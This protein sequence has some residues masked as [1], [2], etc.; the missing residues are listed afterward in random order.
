MGRAGPYPGAIANRRKPHGDEED[1]EEGGEEDRQEV[2][3]EVGQEEGRLA[4]VGSRLSDRG[5]LPFI[6]NHRR[7]R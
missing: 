2:G 7:Q 1:R 6:S 3:S 4:R 5:R